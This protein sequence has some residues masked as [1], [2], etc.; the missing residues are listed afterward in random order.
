MYSASGMS[1]ELELLQMLKAYGAEAV[2]LNVGYN[3]GLFC[4]SLHRKRKV[5][6][7]GEY[8]SMGAAYAEAVCW[9]DAQRKIDIVKEKMY[10]NPPQ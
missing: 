10:G 2:D 4:F 9:L 1:L 6:S 5:F 7:T 3:T 8:E